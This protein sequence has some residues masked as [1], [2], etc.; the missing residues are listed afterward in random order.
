LLEIHSML[1]TQR[2]PCANPKIARF[3]CYQ[4]SRNARTKF[5][6]STFSATRAG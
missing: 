2:W 1:P 3:W 6:P 4:I 5:A